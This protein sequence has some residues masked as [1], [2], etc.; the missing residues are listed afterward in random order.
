VAFPGEKLKFTSTRRWHGRQRWALKYGW[1]LAHVLK[2]IS[3]SRIP[4]CCPL[5]CS[6]SVPVHL[7][8][9]LSSPMRQ[10]FAKSAV[11]QISQLTGKY[12][13][14]K[15][16]YLASKS[17]FTTFRLRLDVVRSD[18][19][20][21]L[22]RVPS[23]YLFAHVA[24]ISAAVFAGSWIFLAP[25][26]EQANPFILV[27]V[28][29]LAAGFFYAHTMWVNKTA[30][31]E[32]PVL[33][34]DLRSKKLAVPSK[35]AILDRDDIGVMLGIAGIHFKAHKP[36]TSRGELKFVFTNRGAIDFVVLATHF[37]AGMQNFDAQITPFVKVLKIPYLHVNRNIG[38]GKFTVDRV[39]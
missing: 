16:L 27:A 24:A 1:W 12:V 20:I 30:A 22:V 6:N 4:Y 28:C 9:Q 36:E 26:E 11:D 32:N 23:S 3:I 33:S 21:D 18:K 39:A 29:A 38:N 35:R 8:I 19:R 10:S 31:E 34:Y 37:N 25:K 7:S 2:K 15:D 13:R 14:D 17:L 5:S